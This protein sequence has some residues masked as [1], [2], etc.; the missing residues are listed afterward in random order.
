MRWRTLLQFGDSLEVIGSAVMK[1][2]GSARFLLINLNKLTETIERFIMRILILFTAIFV[3]S[4][5]VACS[6]D[7]GTPFASEPLAAGTTFE[8]DGIFYNVTS[9]TDMTCK[10]TYGNATWNS[11]LYSGIVDIPENVTYDGCIYSVTS[12]GANAFS[13]CEN[14]TKVIIPNSVTSIGN[15]AFTGCTGLEEVNIPIAVTRIGEQTFSLCKSLKE[16]AIPSSIT[17][18]DNSAFDCC[19]SLTEI[20]IPNTVTYIGS[21]VFSSCSSLEEV[22]LPSDMTNIPKGLFQQCTS[23]KEFTI[24]A[25]VTSIGSYAFNECRGFTEITIPDKVTSIGEFAFS[26]CRSLAAVTSCNPEPPVCDRSVFDNIFT[27]T[28]VLYVPKGAKEA[29]AEA[30]QW[31]KFT[32]IE[33]I[34]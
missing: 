34:E 9:S 19:Y 17:Y 13:L 15:Q 32:N 23:L 30:E 4:A 3:A 8:V 12:I 33:E 29:Y 24:P 5:F 18:I 1:N 25:T 22:V 27:T 14:L 6:D 21:Y 20:T 10:V 11:A 16:I 31:Q 7:D 2:S 26:S 28:C